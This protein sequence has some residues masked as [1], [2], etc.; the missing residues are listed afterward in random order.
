MAHANYYS[1]RLER[2]LISPLY[3]T[4]KALPDGHD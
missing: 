3:H 1:P 4:T 2:D